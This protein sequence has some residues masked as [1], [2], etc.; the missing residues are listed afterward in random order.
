MEP[1]LES[2]KRKVAERL[3][4]Y[5]ERASI[6]SISMTSSIYH[7]FVKEEKESRSLK[8]FF[9]QYSHFARS[10][11]S[12]LK[13]G[14]KSSK[15][16]KEA[17]EICNFNV[18]PDEVLSSAVFTFLLGLVAMIPF[19]I[20]GWKNFA[21]FVF[22]LFIFLAYVS[23]TYPPF[24]SQL[25]KMRAEEEGILAILYMTIYMRVNPV[26][27]NALYFATQ[28]L[29]G[30]LGK[31]L[32]RV[33][34]LLDMQ[35]A[36]SLDEATR[37]FMDLWIK[38]NLDFVKSFMTLH[39]ITDQGDEVEREKIL[40]KSLQSILD[41]TYVKMKHYS[42][43]LKMP[44][45]MLHTFGMLLPLIGLI[46]F[47]MMS[48]FMS[49]SVRIDHL[50][51]G[52]LVIIPALIWF[53]SNRILAKRP[54][55]FSYPDLSKNPYLPPLGKYALKI[56]N[57]T[58][59]I[60]VLKV[61]IVVGV[62]ITIP[63]WIWLFTHTIPSYIHMK[64]LLKSSV[65]GANVI[66]A[67][68]YTT[69]AMFNTVTIPLG[70]ALGI[71]IYFYFRSVQR[72]R[73]RNAIVEIENDLDDALFHLGNEFTE[74]IPVEIALKRYI[75]KAKMLNLKTRSIFRFFSDVLD[76]LE[77]EGKTFSQAVFDR[78]SG[79]I[80]KYPSILMKEIMW[81]ISEGASKGAS[82]LHKITIKVSVYLN[83][84][85]NIRELIY[86]LLT[87]TVSSINMQAKFLTPFLSA[88]VGSLTLI[89]IQT[90]YE[91][92]KRLENIMKMLQ[93][94][95]G[96]SDNFFI[97]LINFTKITPPTIFQVLVGIYMIETV[98]L[99]SILSSGV[100]SGFDKVN[101]DMTIARNLLFA[102]IVYVMLLV[103]G[104]F[105]MNTLV[106]QGIASTT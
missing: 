32:K 25:I 53:L 56:G 3:S 100:N 72:L 39:S 5:S 103:I 97:N 40:E 54:G 106:H 16:L 38:R 82:V 77:N 90:L 12:F 61:A 66:P 17:L 43:D 64:M 42:H 81:I 9:E 14:E 65:V 75:V 52:Y 51:F 95:M 99:L 68:E 18:T 37:G 84:T 22:T 94:S 73:L 105:S 78:Q 2:I 1:S 93:L 87:E 74:N 46:A 98:T 44:V 6:A 49:D 36:S 27:E 8:T 102:I 67:E 86:D 50:F 28:H 92:S 96:A 7:D 30:P 19:A 79:V 80:V 23:Y 89:I 69:T 29:N 35:K 15:K 83:N 104:V 13:M 85:K 24:Y 71:V 11:L 76:K 34:W 62:L 59:Y 10:Y 55:A 70:I 41:A 31:D 33:V 60:P 20:I 91:L 88:V 26:L 4:P 101:R 57:S 48:I 21:F 47:P 58:Y 63:G 45:M